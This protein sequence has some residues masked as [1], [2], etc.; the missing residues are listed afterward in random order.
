MKIGEL[1]RVISIQAK[2]KTPDGLGSW[3]ETWAEYAE[4][5][6]AIWPV[7]ASEQVRNQQVENQITHKVRVR[8][9]T[10]IIPEMRV[11]Y[12]SRVFEILGQPINVNEE[13]RWLDLLCLESS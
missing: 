1:K 3:S 4:T 12:K 6:A 13:N 2:T 7:S 8:Y 10:G 9:Q 11:V 5:R